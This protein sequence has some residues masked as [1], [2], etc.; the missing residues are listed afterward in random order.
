M[1]TDSELL[2]DLN[3][4]FVRKEVVGDVDYFNALLAPAFAMRHANGQF[5]DRDAFL[6]GVAKSSIRITG[7]PS[8]TMHGDTRAVVTCIVSI[9]V[10]PEIKRVHNLRLFTRSGTGGEWQLLAWANELIPAASL[11]P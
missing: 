2:I 3:M 9:A 1:P 8:V 10:G 7:A 4:D 11:V 6:A 5:N